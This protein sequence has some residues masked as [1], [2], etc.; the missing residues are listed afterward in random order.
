M[1]IAYLSGSQFSSAGVV[2]A[3]A[4]TGGT[5]IVGSSLEEVE[6][7]IDAKADGVNITSAP[8]L[9]DAATAGELSNNGM[10]Y[11]DLEAVIKEF[12]KAVPPDDLSRFDA[13]GASNLGPLKAFLMTGRNGTDHSTVRMF[14]LIR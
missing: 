14:L 13:L 10:I 2:P 4:V 1:S 8:N 3:Y 12:R 9:V 6:A 11:I 7:I 5:A